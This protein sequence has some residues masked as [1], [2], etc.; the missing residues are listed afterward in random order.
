MGYLLVN[1]QLPDSASLERTQEVI[2]ADARRS[3]TRP[4]ASTRTVGDR[5]PVA[6]AERLRVELRHDVRDARRP[7][8][9][10]TTP[11]DL[12]Y[13]AIANKLRGRLAER[14]HRRRRSPIFGPPPVRGVGPGRRL[15]DHDRGPRRPG[16][17]G[18][19]GADREPS[20]SQANQ[21]PELDRGNTS[22]F[23]ANVPQVFLDVDRTA[24]MIKEVELQDVFETLQ[25]YLGS[26]YVNDFNL[27]GRTWQVIV[28][29][30]AKYPRPDGRH[31]PAEGAQR[32]RDDGARS[33]RWPDVREIDGPL[34]L[35]R[36]N[37]YPA[38]SI[39]GNAAPGVSSGQAIEVMERLANDELPKS[40]AVR[41]DR[42]GLPRAPGGQHGDDRLRLRGRDGLP[43]AGG[44]VRELVAAAG[45]HPGRCRMCLLSAI[46]RACNVGGAGHQ[47]LHPDRLRRAGRAWRARTRS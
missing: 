45:G 25:V 18:P 30:E 32:E 4:R 47:H 33:G 5:R 35:T 41:V 3:P 1:V 10:R 26:L 44:A 38:A 21:Q 16:A 22:V 2:D 40:M 31:Q 23:R 27:F 15:H 39:N 42:A 24:C 46:D 14:G 9:E 43:G 37:M 17:A 36:Y 13:E 29:A 34:V 19:P 6:P 28:Q 20:S 11:D 12:Y 8:D 7:F